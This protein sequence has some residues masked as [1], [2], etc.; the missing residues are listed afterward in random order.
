MREYGFKEGKDHCTILCNGGGF[1]KSA[2]RTDHAIGIPMAKELCMLQRT[3]KGK[4]FR[5]YFISCEEDNSYYHLSTQW[6]HA[7][8]CKIFLYFFGDFW[9]IQKSHFIKVIRFANKLAGLTHS[10]KSG[11]AY[12]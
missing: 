7:K 6:L 3:P 2:I 10:F 4:E 11:F 8:V 1:G 9:F 12:A 5:E